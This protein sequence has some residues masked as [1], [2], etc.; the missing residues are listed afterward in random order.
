MIIK[1]DLKLSREFFF[2]DEMHAEP[3]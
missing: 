1:G 3:E 2:S